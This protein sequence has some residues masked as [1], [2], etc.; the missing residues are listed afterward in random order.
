MGK[1][2]GSAH[3]R[4]DLVDAGAD[5]DGSGQHL[6]VHRAESLCLTQRIFALLKFKEVGRMREGR[7]QQR[8]PGKA[9]RQEE[10]ECHGPSPSV[11]QSCFFVQGCCSTS[12]PWP[13]G[14][15]AQPRSGLSSRQASQAKGHGQGVKSSTT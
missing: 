3:A 4:Q 14:E 11:L 15:P 13:S 9:G 6:G 12:W 8:S 1:G 7:E 5:F 2:P 10:P